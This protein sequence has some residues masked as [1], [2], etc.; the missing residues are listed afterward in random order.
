MTKSN[1][2][3]QTCLTTTCEYNPN[4]EDAY[5]VDVADDEVK[6]FPEV[7]DIHEFTATKG[8]AV[9]SSFIAPLDILEEEIK[10]GQKKYQEMIATNENGVVYT[11]AAKALS[12]CLQ[13]IQKLKQVGE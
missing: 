3:C 4:N 5:F 8:C 10:G 7:K 1:Y 9:H 13:R 6:L 2:N 11:L 12:V